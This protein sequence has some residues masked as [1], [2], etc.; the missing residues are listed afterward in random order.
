MYTDVQELAG[1][2]GLDTQ[3]S[4]NSLWSAAARAGIVD[5]ERWVVA[6]VLWQA[7]DAVASTDKSCVPAVQSPGSI[8]GATKIIA[9]DDTPDAAAVSTKAMSLWE[10]LRDEAFRSVLSR[11][12]KNDNHDA[13]SNAEPS[14]SSPAKADTLSTPRKHDHRREGPLVLVGEDVISHRVDRRALQRYKDLRSVP[15]SFDRALMSTLVLASRAR[16]ASAAASPTTG[17]RALV[18]SGVGGSLDCVEDILLHNFVVAGFADGSCL[19]VSD[20]VDAVSTRRQRVD[21]TATAGGPL[22]GGAKEG[23]D[24]GVGLDENGHQPAKPQ[25][26]TELPE[27]H[28]HRLSRGELVPRGETRAASAI[29]GKEEPMSDDN[30][31]AVPT[32]MET[33]AESR[34]LLGI[35]AELQEL[36][37]AAS[38]AGVV[39]KKQQQQQ[40]VSHPKASSI[41]INSVLCMLAYLLFTRFIPRCTTE[42]GVYSYHFFLSGPPRKPRKGWAGKCGTGFVASPGQQPDPRNGPLLGREDSLTPRCRTGRPFL[43]SPATRS[44][45]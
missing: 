32:S 35:P 41:D 4:E 17:D 15:S 27:N 33:D 23:M 31:V 11:S 1:I 8:E 44:G 38:L 36:F 20:I 2:G 34:L 45:V 28:R 22:S 6:A 29:K 13:A 37:R 40:H 30:A 7:E 43:G 24:N 3:T 21:L 14:T 12:S 10:E 26:L 42:S 39:R 16:A 9:G 19:S 18:D 25:A 5:V